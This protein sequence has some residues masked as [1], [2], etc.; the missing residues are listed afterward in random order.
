[1]PCEDLGTLICRTPCPEDDPVLKLQCPY[2]G[3]ATQSL[4]HSVNT[5]AELK[6]GTY[7]IPLT[8]TTRAFAFNY[9]SSGAKTDCSESVT[10]SGSVQDTITH[11]S[12]TLYFIDIENTACLYLER[13][14]NITVSGSGN[15]PVHVAVGGY[16]DTFCGVEATYAYSYTDTWYFIHG[17]KREKLGQDTH[18][19]SSPIYF[20]APT[21]GPRNRG[22][23]VYD[24]P[25]WVN[26][27]Y[28][29]SYES[30]T[31]S[32]V[33]SFVYLDGG[34][35]MFFPAWARTMVNDP[36]WKDAAERRW[37]L[38][39]YPD[40]GAEIKAQKDWKYPIQTEP[41]PRGDYKKHPELGE[42]YSWLVSDKGAPLCVNRCDYADVPEQ[43]KKLVT[44][45]KNILVFPIGLV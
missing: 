39:K 19:N 41:I 31:E 38:L 4:N 45:K 42:C 28:Y 18:T 21:P 14:A 15:T 22:N 11:V 23:L 20:Y 37:M 44:I 6:I 16:V 10:M 24:P 25:A 43:L 13:K 40:T 30:I 3:S 32:E 35:D 5:N 26:R 33:G 9:S 8:K 1:M 2:S 34:R 27:S 7:T 36:I 17:D 12:S 29:N